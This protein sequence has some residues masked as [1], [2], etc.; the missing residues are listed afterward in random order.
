MAAFQM[1]HQHS[2]VVEFGAKAPLKLKNE[3]TMQIIYHISRLTVV[4]KTH[5]S[6]LREALIIISISAP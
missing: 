4:I 2:L 5:G 3:H 1:S 6:E